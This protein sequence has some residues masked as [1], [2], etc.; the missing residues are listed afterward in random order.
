MNY[1]LIAGPIGR[2]LGLILLLTVFSLG[3][4]TINGWFL[5]S[6]DAGVVNNERFDR[7]VR[8]GHPQGA[9]RRVGGRYRGGEVHR[10]LTRPPSG[11][12]TYQCSGIMTGGCE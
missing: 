10:R 5:N 4:G 3:I 11:T 7:V 2:I 9:G 12:S 8:G 1:N 6:V